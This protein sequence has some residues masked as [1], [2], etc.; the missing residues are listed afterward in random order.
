MKIRN[1]FVSN[2]SSSSF[3][4]GI[5]K[6]ENGNEVFDINDIKP[7]EYGHGEVIL[8]KDYEEIDVKFVG[9]GEYSLSYESFTG[10]RV[11]CTLKDE[12]RFTFLDS[13]GPD[14]DYFFWEEDDEYYNYDKI[15][16]DDFDSDDIVT[17]ELIQSLGGQCSYGAGR[18]G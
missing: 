6:N 8:T 13:V 4:I 14:D 17:Y 5:A 3:I 10:V 15:D 1:G 12:D 7:S 2:S 11:S 18:N 9:N 16:L